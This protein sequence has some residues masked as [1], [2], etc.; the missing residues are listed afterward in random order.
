[1]KVLV[2]GLGGFVGR[3]L[4]PALA[5]RGHAVTGTRLPGEP[6][7]PL[8][9][10]LAWRPLELA[11]AATVRRALEPC[12]EAVIHLAAVASGAEARLDPPRALEVNGAG[13][14]R[15][16]EALGAHREAGTGDPLLLLVSTAEVYGAG[17][18][19]G[20]RRETDPVRPISPYAA[21]KV[22]AEAAALEAAGR[23]GLRVVIARPFPHTGPGQMDR[24]VIPA[25]ARRLL[26]AR[27]AGETRVATGN[28]EPVRDYLDVRDVVAA[29]VGL[30]EQGHAGEI[31]NVASGAGWSLREVFQRLA[32][33]IGV[34]AEPVPDPALVRSEDLMHLVGDASRLRARTGWAPRIPFDQTLQDVVNAQTD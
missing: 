6:D 10:V 5:A 3:W 33:L 29:Y 25:F 13:T 20:L 14:G 15:L 9:G 30:L 1:M 4:L 11:D 17:N 34:P 32:R 24:Y 28:L 12:P 18:G 21:S 23:T 19:S 31:Y 27:R 26:V 22:A 8:A 2:T 7:P 16:A